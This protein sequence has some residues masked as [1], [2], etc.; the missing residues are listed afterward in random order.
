M[1]RNYIKNFF[2]HL[3]TITHHRHLVIRYAFKVGIGFQGL[4]HDLSKYS[5]TEFWPGVKY[6][7][8]TKSPTLQ[9]RIETGMS[10]AWMHH[11]GRNKHHYEYWT[12]YDLTDQGYKPVKMP[13]RYLKEMFC[14]RLAASKTY[15]KKSYT[16]SH[17]Y[18]Y[19][20]SKKT[21]ER[22]HED[23]AKTLEEWL[24]MLKDKGEKATFKYIKKIKNK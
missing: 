4:F 3:Y 2:G 23:T 11:K 1:K 7:L 20:V 21:I 22:M 15:M 10:K 13:T 24:I 8:G 9:E 18:E 16:D 17:P 12:D 5:C 19:F 6:Y 14:D